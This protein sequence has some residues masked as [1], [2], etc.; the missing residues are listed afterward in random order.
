MFN[1]I[2]SVIL[3]Q[4]ALI[5]P[6]IISLISEFIT[7]NIKAKLILCFKNHKEGLLLL[8]SNYINVLFLIIFFIYHDG[9]LQSLILA[10]GRKSNY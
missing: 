2:Y 3:H 5:S 7:I 4:Q 9:I 8:N 1:L 10:K 6:L